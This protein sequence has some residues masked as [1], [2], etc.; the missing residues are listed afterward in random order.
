MENSTKQLILQ[1][2][3]ILSGGVQGEAL[4]AGAKLCFAPARPSSFVASSCASPTAKSNHIQCISLNITNFLQ[5]SPPFFLRLRNV[6]CWASLKILI[7]VWGRPWFQSLDI[8]LFIKNRPPQISFAISGR[9]WFRPPQIS[10]EISGRTWCYSLD[11]AGND[12]YHQDR[13]PKICIKIS[14]RTWLKLLK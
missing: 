2:Q 13:P 5:T 1:S 3:K 7:K 9:T 11:M 10:F 12:H 14:W 8:D 6:I 4:Q